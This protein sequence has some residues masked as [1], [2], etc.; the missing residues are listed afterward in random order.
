MWS[1]E[2]SRRTARRSLG[3]PVIIPPLLR[4]YPSNGIQENRHRH[5]WQPRHRP[6]GR[7]P[8]HEGRP[9]RGGRRARPGQVR[10]R[11]RS[12]QGRRPQCRGLPARRER[13]EERA[14]L[15]RAR[16]ET[17]RRARR[18]REQRGRLSG[19]DRGEGRG[20]AHVHVARDARDQPV[21]RGAHVPRGRPAHEE[22]SLRARGEHLQ[23]PGAAAPDRRGEPRL[24]RV[25]I[26]VECAHPHAR[27]G[28][29]RLGHPRE[30]HQPGLGANRHARGGSA[31]LGRGGRRHRGV[32]GAPAFERPDR[33]VLS[34]PQAHSL[35]MSGAVRFAAAAAAIL[36]LGACSLQRLAYSNVALAYSN[37]SP[38]LAWMAGDYVDMTDEQKE[39]VRVRIE[40]AFACHR[41]QELPEY[42]R[43]LERVLEQ[44]RDDISVE[45]ARAALRDIREAYHR[46]L[47]RIVPDL[48]E[49]LSQIDA[50]Q[51]KQLERSF[52]RDNRKFIAESLRGTPVER[53]ERRVGKLLDNLEEFTGPLSAAQR[54]LVTERAGALPEL[55]DEQLADRRY[56]QA[57]ILALVRS[58]PPR[59]KW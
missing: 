21:W 9:L 38:V 13:H 22:A 23:R 26:R 49:F 30:L 59:E 29:R 40:R 25:Q 24:P 1:S 28:G 5:R 15:R 2:S 43:F 55:V 10:R 33:T 27:R 20:H 54:A 16:G 11:R 31:T 18:P 50:E 8:A 17:P 34:R 52:A 36:L 56:R 19:I 57:E 58:N 44:S 46:T 32:A 53:R 35:V 4:S 51:A 45:E 3:I 37:A 39:W 12:A 42:R 41:E 47:D 6:R 48:A 14:P 7:A